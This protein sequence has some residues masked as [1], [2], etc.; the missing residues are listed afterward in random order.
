MGAPETVHKLGRYVIGS[1]TATGETG[2]GKEL[3]ERAMHKRSQ[4]SGQAFIS[5]NC[6]PRKSSLDCCLC[7]RDSFWIDAG[8]FPS[9]EPS[10][11][12]LSTPQTEAL[13]SQE[14][15]IETALA[16]SKG[17]VAEPNGAAAKLGVPRTTL[18]G[19]NQAARHK[20]TQACA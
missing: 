2:A 14:E 6:F 4:P 12:G 11:A 10:R 13:E 19:K 8:W 16:E 7:N 18:D 9:Q 20:E 3:I 17:K 15:M 5:V 1:G